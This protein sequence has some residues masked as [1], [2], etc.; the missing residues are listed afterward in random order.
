MTAWRERLARAR[1]NWHVFSRN[2]LSVIGLC[3]LLLI[4]FS[5]AFAPWIVPYRESAGLYLNFDE[6]NQAPSWQHP[7]GTDQMG[8]DVFSRVVFGYRY[9]LLLAISVLGM[10]APLGILLGLVAGY[11]KD[12]WL[13]MVIMRGTEIFLSIP[14]LLLALVVATLLRPTQFNAMVAVAATWWPW[15]CRLM[16]GMVSSLRNEYYVR[17]AEVLNAGKAHI[18]LREIMPNTLSPLFTK[19]SFDAGVVIIIGSMLSFVGLGVQPPEPG[20]G[21]MVANGLQFLP[22]RWWIPVFPSLA[23]LLV[24]LSFNLIGDGLRD[25]L[26]GG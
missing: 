4:S 13:D 1:R 15:Y 7:F 9:S 18:L 24:V 25:V 10:V 8:R 14:S 26:G 19:L 23:I 11:W 6:A 21:T 17:A 2:R 16:Y 5:A 12:T 22:E 3:A 20:L